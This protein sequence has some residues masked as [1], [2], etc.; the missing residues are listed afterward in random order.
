MELNPHIGRG[1]T[2]GC[3]QDVARQKSAWIGSINRSQQSHPGNLMHLRQRGGKF[4][5]GTVIDPTLD[6]CQ[7]R[8][9]GGISNSQNEGEAKFGTILLVQV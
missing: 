7:H 5:L 3:V 9:L 1:T 4:N 8:M 6:G 2:V